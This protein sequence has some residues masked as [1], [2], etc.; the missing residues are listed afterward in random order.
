VI[1]ISL[2]IC[3]GVSRCSVAPPFSL[4]LDFNVLF[5]LMNRLSY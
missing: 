4:R 5:T 3:N 2:E 1:F